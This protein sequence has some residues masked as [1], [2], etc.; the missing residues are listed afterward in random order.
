MTIL[1]SLVC[2]TTAPVSF[3][4]PPW[5]DDDPRRLELGQRLDPDHLARRIDQAVARL[6]LSPLWQSYAG[7]GSLPHRPDLLLRAV[8]YETQRGQHSPAAWHRDSTESEPLRWLLRGC[9]PSRSCW[10][11]F[12]DHL[13]P[14]LDEFNRQTL[15]Q[16]IDEGLTPATRGALDG[17]L[18]AANA[19]RHKLVN[20]ATL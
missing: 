9:T 17:T 3:A 6:D 5:T 2:F 19:S 20:Q 12:R 4:A 16:A 1:V 10:Y 18:V 14:F 7:T 11:A 13:A 8:L 15:H